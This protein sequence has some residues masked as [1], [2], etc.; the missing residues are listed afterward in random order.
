MVINQKFKNDPYLIALLGIIL[1]NVVLKW[2]FFCGLVQADDFSYGVYSYTL[3]KG[4]WPWNMDMDFRMLRFG[5]MLPVRLVFFMLP[6]VEFAAVL[7][8]MAASIGTIIMVYFIGNKIH[9]HNVGLLSAFVLATFPADIIFGTMILPDILV[10][11]YLSAAA[12]AFL[13]TDTEKGYRQKII[14]T[15]AGFFIF[16][17][18]ITRE[19][20]YYFLLFFLPFVFSIN[21]WKQGLYLIGFGFVIPIVLLYGIYYIKTGDFLFNVHLAVKARDPQIASGYIPPNSVNLLT[22][23]KYM[24]PVTNPARR[25]LMSSLY[26]LTFYVGIPCVIYSGIKAIREKNRNLLIVIWWFCLGYLFL[27]FGTLS[28]SHYQMM[29]KL[30]RF[31]LTITPAMALGYGVVL[32]DA[33]GFGAKRIKKLKGLKIRWSTGAIALILMAVVLVTSIQTAHNQKLSRD[34]NMEQFRWGYN[35]VLK[36]H[37]NKPVYLTGGWWPNKLSFYFLPDVRYADMN[38]RRSEMLRDL[39]AVKYPSEL[40]GSYVII[41]RKHF[42]GQ[43]DLRIQHSYDEFGTYV[44]LPPPEWK[45]LGSQ[46]HVEIYKVPEGWTYREPD[47]QEMA[48]KVILQAV[49]SDDPMRFVYSLHPDFRQT[50]DQ[51]KFYALFNTMRNISENERER[52][53]DDSIRFKE[54]NGKWKVIFNKSGE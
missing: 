17:A 44:L 7:Y 53:I 13:Y 48:K 3:F 28:F 33:L 31:L 8:P 12:L 9:G 21:R 39:K 32:C 25:I 6:P 22:Q 2:Q 47:G 1:V 52:Y 35:D 23:L 19:N 46:Y 38:G 51:Q 54:S 29:K 15:L 45:L 4:I 18:F 10:P 43:N 26:G 11:F 34:T 16:L 20:S 36:G 30:P 5:L 50:L 40:D 42:T 24:L 14:Y 49:V 27:E 41:D 37:P